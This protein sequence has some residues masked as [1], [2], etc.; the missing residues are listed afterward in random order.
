MK[1]KRKLILVTII[2]TVIFLF[3]ILHIQ[4][5]NDTENVTKATLLTDNEITKYLPF[6]EKEVNPEKYINYSRKLLQGQL[7]VHENF[8]EVVQYDIDNINW[9]IEA[10]KSP[11]T[12][13]LYLHSLRPVFY[14]SMSY[15]YTNDYAFLDAADKII[16][17]W[18]NYDRNNKKKNRYAWYD[19]SVAERTENLV[20]FAK[21][22]GTRI[23]DNYIREIIQKNADWLMESK[24][25][26]KN[27]NHGIF[28]DGA[29]LKAGYY[30]NRSDYI[31]EAISRLDSQ[32]K[33]AFPNKY[34]HIENSIGYHQGIISYLKNV[35]DFLN[36][37][38]SDYAT[39]AMEYLNGALD[40]LVYVMKPNSAF[41]YIGDTLGSENQ[42][43]NIPDYGNPELKYV[44]SFGKEGNMPKY[45]TRVYM[46]D[47]YV[48]FREHWNPENYKNSTWLMFKS[49]YLSSTHKHADDLSII[50]YSK[51]KDIFIDPGMYNYMVGE[52]IHDYMNSAFAH[53]TVIVDNKSYSVGMF[54]SRKVGIYEYKKLENY[55]VAVGYNNVYPGVNI[56]RS[57]IYINGDHFFIVDDIIAEQ[58]HDYSQIFHLSNDVKLT[59]F[60]SQEVILDILDT[61]YVVLIQQLMDNDSLHHYQ[62]N[63][64]PDK[65]S[66][67]STGFNKVKETNTIV[68]NK[69]G[70]STRFVTSIR[71]IKRDELDYYQKQ[72]PKLTEDYIDTGDFEIP[73]VSRERIP[74]M[75]ISVSID[76]NNIF[77]SNKNNTSEQ[78][79][80]SY[81]LLDKETGSKY[82]SVSYSAED[83]VQFELSENGSYALVAYMR[84][85]AKE[86]SKKLAGFIE[87]NDSGYQFIELAK[88]QQEPY[89]VNSKV[90]KIT[91]NKYKFFVDIKNMNK[92]SSKWYIY[93][94]GASYDFIGN[95]KLELEYTFT[96]PGDYT[97]IYRINDVYFGE[98]EYNHFESI[99]IM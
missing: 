51:G 6:Y 98:V 60:D 76:R 38:G 35:T 75:N 81:Y 4:Y 61:D 49:G 84:N 33:Y 95:D 96:E 68:F 34:V 29:L 32:L 1:I 31:E 47:G 30:L 57:I 85:K 62:G 52:E 20:L 69:M 74:N 48:I 39:T 88:D 71:I 99:K 17:S 40:F 86:T 28:Q 78:L 42:T 70:K 67:I 12:F 79:Y 82:A 90:E 73:L 2:I 25:Y 9:D 7:V 19:H 5:I 80:Y 89:V 26:T 72:K 24:N 92:I 77:I 43:S 11:N 94:N 23:N 14:L 65:L 91:D 15:L 55:E 50:L 83:E 66:Y 36:E 58:H 41:P 10:T 8:D 13:S 37:M 97:V 16:R 56:D 27:H 3:S 18:E 53:N 22:N 45:N 87:K 44:N 64:N 54:N 63:E 21:I 46:D 93:R 59:H